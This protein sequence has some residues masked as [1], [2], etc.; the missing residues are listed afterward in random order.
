MSP[1]WNKNKA[2]TT[3]MLRNIPNK[4]SQLE[5]LEDVI[6]VGFAP[7]IQIDFFYLPIDEKTGLNK[8]Y[9]FLNFITTEYCLEFQKIFHQKPMRRYYTNK[10]T[11]VSYGNFQGLRG[12]WFYYRR[13][14]KSAHDDD[15]P[16]FWPLTKFADDMPLYT[17]GTDGVPV[18]VEAARHSITSS[19]HCAQDDFPF[20][21]NSTENSQE[22]NSCSNGSASQSLT[23]D[24]SDNT[25]LTIPIHRAQSSNSLSEVRTNVDSVTSYPIKTQSTHRYINDYYNNKDLQQLRINNNTS[26]SWNYNNNNDRELFS[27]SPSPVSQVSPVS[28]IS[29]GSTKIWGLTED[30][31]SRCPVDSA[32]FSNF[33]FSRKQS[34][35]TAA[36]SNTPSHWN[37][38]SL[39]GL[40]SPTTVYSSVNISHST[41][42]F[43]ICRPTAV[44]NGQQQSTNLQQQEDPSLQPV[45]LN[46]SIGGTTSCD[47][48]SI[49]SGI[50]RTE[51]IHSGI[52]RT[53]VGDVTTLE[54]PEYKSTYMLQN[55]RNIITQTVMMGHLKKVGLLAGEHYDF[56]YIPVETGTGKNMCYAFINFTSKEAVD[57][58]LSLEG[59][60]LPTFFQMKV[61]KVIE[62]VKEA[63]VQGFEA[64]LT[65]YAKY[66]IQ[67]SQKKRRP[68][69][70]KDGERIS[71]LG[72]LRK[73]KEG[74]K[75]NKDELKGKGLEIK[76]ITSNISFLQKQS[77]NGESGASSVVST[78][79]MSTCTTDIVRSI[80]L[81]STR[82]NY[83]NFSPIRIE[84]PSIRV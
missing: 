28:Q 42:P 65:H 69:F 33:T 1:S 3:L 53:V 50:N 70:W 18:L 26:S 25:S 7:A 45:K 49:H 78:K 32:N 31:E 63:T 80:S 17:V 64:N 59:S 51:S 20:G 60:T 12:L 21:C 82:Y 67:N 84:L 9:C 6:K 68:I 47:I 57:T 54:E 55:I 13:Q 38:A 81:T 61:K 23:N 83:D 73:K 14:V 74:E 71:K 36:A 66:I 52:N 79:K 22:L 40:E 39:R 4:Y 35:L 19:H 16:L 29:H 37:S 34:M 10:I 56:L 43:L 44:V 27:N 2:L 5:L 8:G 41:N 58:F 76:T 75:E 11:E 77:S 15:V 62:S 48:K 30:E 72:E 24:S 46:A